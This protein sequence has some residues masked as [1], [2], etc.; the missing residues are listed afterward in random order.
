[1]GTV[2]N[3]SPT[4]LIP[5]LVTGHQLRRVCDAEN[6]YKIAH[7]ATRHL[8]IQTQGG[9]VLGSILGS[10]PRTRMTILHVVRRRS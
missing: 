7:V 1:M 8:T 9:W 10:N 6:S 5:V 2:R 4:S 3:T